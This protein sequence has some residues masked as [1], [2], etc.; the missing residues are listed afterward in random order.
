[1]EKKLVL[2]YMTQDVIN[3][4]VNETIGDVIHLIRT[5]R[6]DGFPVVRQNKV[7]GYIS[8]RDIIGEHP[9][10][11][12]D[13]RMSRHPIKATPNLTITE[14]ARRIFRSG[15]QK[16]PVVDDEN[17]LIGI[18]S[19]VDVIRSQIERVTPEKVFN[20]MSTLRTLYGVDP[21]LSRETIQVSDIQP[22]QSL[23]F[24]EELDGRIYELKMHLAEPVIA[25][26]CCGRLILV[27][28]HHRAIAA[29]MLDIS[30][31]DAYVV[32]IEADIELG[33]EKTAHSMN[34]YTL[35]D[36]QIDDGP[37]HSLIGSFHPGLISTEKK[38]ISDY[39]TTHV[40]SVPVSGTV[41]DVIWLIRSTTHDGF[42]VVD[43][44]E[45]VVGFIAARG[46]VG[47]A[48]SDPI[49]KLME[50]ELLKINPD[51]DL[52]SVARKMFRFCIQKLPVTNHQ[53]KLI[54]IITN[55]DVIRSQI[56]KV[57]PEKVFD[58]IH[59][60]KTL[61][62]VQP[63]LSR[64]MVSVVRLMPTQSKVYMDELDGRSY[65]IVKGL[66]EP[67]IVV[68]RPGKL[69]LI[70]GHHRA[71]AANLMHLKELEAYIIDI[72]PDIELGIEKTA[73]NMRLRSLD[74]VQ[75][76]DESHCAFLA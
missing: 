19:N 76:L 3:V 29:Q 17:T 9:L 62:G 1:M 51:S 34:I 37:E 47:A 72:D 75:V 13:Q 4:D 31:L 70:D 74:D 20:F 14:V 8:A 16:L 44:E 10:T 63:Q 67:L 53:N 27:D 40:F 15:I 42:P 50:G 28:G 32:Y 30:E 46:I 7:V 71:V 54:G 11:T 6:H 49:A 12:V 58:Y 59:T 64:G 66:D 39:M 36:V 48:A 60:L 25:V 52:T 68:R 61:Y 41:K 69:I 5:T 35:A 2:D 43:E 65:E 21:K 55:V 33:L 26:R 23:V 18:I 24:Q 22:T 73:R 38:V 56:E 57:T 45:C